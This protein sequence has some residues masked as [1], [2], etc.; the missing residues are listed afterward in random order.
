M[1]EANINR[2]QTVATL[3]QARQTELNKTDHQVA[4]ALGYTHERVVTMIKTGA[5][6]LP[7]N[8]VVELAGVLDVDAAQLF[9]LLLR[10]TNP[11]ILDAIERVLG[12]MT[13]TPGEVKLIHAVR[14]VAKG[15]DAVPIMFDRDAVVALIVA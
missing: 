11:V 8:L 4:A 5:M 14:K 3:I 15:R 13:L 7:V 9:R 6:Q 1:T 12:P 2:H 10:E